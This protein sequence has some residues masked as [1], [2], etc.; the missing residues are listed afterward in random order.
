MCGRIVATQPTGVLAEYFA[1]D[2][3]RV[4]AP[5]PNWNVAP[6]DP[7]PV[8]VVRNEHRLLGQMRWGLIPSWSADARGAA[9]L[10]NA[11]AE[12]VSSKPAFRNAFARRRCLIPADGFYEWQRHP[13]VKT[14]PWYIHR[15]DGAPMPLA[16]VWEEWRDPAT[17][18]LVRTCAV[19]TTKANE[20]MAPI[21]DRIPV[22]IEAD[23]WGD[24]LDP[25]LDDPNEVS[26][27]LVAADPRLLDRH[28]VSDQVNSVRNN[29]AELL[30]PLA[31]A[32]SVDAR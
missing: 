28:R 4:E 16:G 7:V 9:R 5:E 27:L 31:D 25:Q 13:D 29:G 1:V 26:Q 19:I 10:I 23:R 30:D 32:D 20:W 2:E 14:K 17:D 6:T 3:V 22:I 21:H 24:W 18:E 15:A 8:V 11:R 12:S